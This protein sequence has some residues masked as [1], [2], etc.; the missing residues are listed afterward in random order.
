MKQKLYVKE[1]EGL[2]GLLAAWVALGH[3]FVAL[4]VGRNEYRGSLMNVDAV[5]VFIILSGFVIF[6]LLGNRRD[7]P[8]FSY[9][10]ARFFRIFPVYFSVLLLSTLMLH[11]DY[12]VVSVS[13]AGTATA[14][15]LTEMAAAAQRPI[16]HFLVHLTML[17]GI[18]PE[19]FLPY[20]AYTL[21]GQAWSISVEWQFYL[22]APLLFVWTSKMRDWRSLA[23][24]FAVISIC[25]FYSHYVTSGFF[26]ANLVPFAVGFASYYFYQSDFTRL[27]ASS[28]RLFF[29]SLFFLGV[30]LAHRHIV[31]LGVWLLVF[32]AIVAARRS[33]AGTNVLTKLLLLPPVLYLGRISY[34]VYLVHIQVL[35][36]LMWFFHI[37]NVPIAVQY[38]AL[39]IG[40]L[41]GAIGLGSALH[42]TVEAPFHEFGKRLS[43]SLQRP[44]PAAPDSLVE[45]V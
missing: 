20:T 11:A 4:P 3:A 39:P 45:E 41:A 33:P 14:M 22:I 28:V 13:P 37:A 6:T 42:H 44:V 30:V 1:F 38:F 7:L 31:G 27:P 29:V 5:D 15:R 2:R 16:T 35:F 8:Y 19:H 32:Y 21:V 34:S 24:L 40:C 17:Q 43:V 12:H 18:I 9:L 10:T 23:C 26:G 36:A 25:V